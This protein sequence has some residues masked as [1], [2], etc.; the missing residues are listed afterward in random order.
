M[1]KLLERLETVNGEIN[2]N[3][4]NN[5]NQIGFLK[6]AEQKPVSDDLKAVYSMQA[7]MIRLIKRKIEEH[8][9]KLTGLEVAGITTALV[10]LQKALQDRE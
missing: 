3:T 6:P 4:R 9:S 5:L 2:S 1:E 8:G 10:E 7:A